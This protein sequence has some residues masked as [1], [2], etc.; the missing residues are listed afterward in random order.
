MKCKILLL[1][2]LFA[3]GAH[4]S[5]TNAGSKVIVYGIE[6]WKSHLRKGERV[7]GFETKIS[8]GAVEAVEGVPSGWSIEIRNDPSWECSVSGSIYVG[9][10]AVD[11]RRIAALLRIIPEPG[12]HDKPA[13]TVTI[14]STRDFAHSNEHYVG[15]VNLFAVGSS[16]VLDG[17]EPTGRDG[18]PKGAS[19]TQEGRQQQKGTESHLNN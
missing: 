14:Q 15:R 12:A 13:V 4:A 10:A 8:G 7:V 16:N 6:P 17:R 3:I 11:E 9:A 18:K 5:E 19:D 1:T 2:L